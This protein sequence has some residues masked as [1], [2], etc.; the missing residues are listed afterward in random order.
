MKKRVFARAF[1]FSF[2]KPPE[3]NLLRV[4]ALAALFT[5]GSVF[6]ALRANGA[7]FT[8][9][10][11]TTEICADYGAAYFE[12]CVKYG[13]TLALLLIL[14]GTPWVCGMCAVV[15]FMRGAALGFAAALLT[16]FFGA[17]GALRAF[18][19]FIP[20]N[21]IL[22]PAYI[23][24]AQIG[25]AGFTGRRRVSGKDL[26]FAAAFGIPAVLAAGW[27]EVSA[28]GRFAPFSA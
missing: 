23:F 6:G 7:G 26:I 3:I 18:S 17:S 25:V 24:A 9:P 28:V 27:V 10:Y 11:L 8:P 12:C 1:A 2:P 20:Q 4:S 5:A 13:R 16:R 22:T 15:V 21:L 14:S 19:L